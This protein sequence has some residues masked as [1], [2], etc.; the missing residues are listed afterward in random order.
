[1]QQ[2]PPHSYAA[3]GNYSVTLTAGNNHF[4]TSD[5]VRIVHVTDTP[6]V[7]FAGLNPQY[8]TGETLSLSTAIT[9]GNITGYSWNNGNGL[10]V[11]NQS[12]VNFVYHNEGNY[13]ITLTAIDKYCGSSAA[14][15]TIPVYQVP[16]FNLGTDITLCPGMTRQI[17]VDA[18]AGYTY[19]WN[20][21]AG[22]SRIVTSPI[23][24]T[25]SLLINN[26]GCSSADEIVVNV[27]DNCLI[28]VPGAFTPNGDGRND[29]LKAI[30]ADLATA[31]QFRV[32]NRFG[33]LVY[34]SRVPTAGWDG[35]IKGQEAD[36]GTYV[37]QLSFKDPTTGKDVFEKGTSILIR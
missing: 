25:Y 9:N 22:T 28:K 10:T 19:L 23:T 36:A 32:Y 26:H 8:C 35:R 7:R 20:N 3:A 21:G 6:T 13:P 24:T 12:P 30:N 34:A 33:Q 1:G 16:V 29:L 31:F 18:T 27:L 15:A 4:C 11:P 5:S 2:P 17:G 14:V 37:W